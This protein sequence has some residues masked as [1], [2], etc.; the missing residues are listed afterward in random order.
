[1]KQCKAC[2]EMYDFPHATAGWNK[3]RFFG[4]YCPYCGTFNSDINK[5]SV[6][7]FIIFIAIAILLYLSGLL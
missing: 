7:S 5:Y 6:I 4:D 1:M 3:I 2:K